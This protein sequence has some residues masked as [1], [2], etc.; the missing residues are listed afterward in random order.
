M[1]KRNYGESNLKK[2]IYIYIQIVKTHAKCLLRQTS[3]LST[4]KLN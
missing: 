2:K 3:S 4:E 1:R